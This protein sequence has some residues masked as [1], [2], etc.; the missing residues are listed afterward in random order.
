MKINQIILFLMFFGLLLFYACAPGNQNNQQEKQTQTHESLTSNRIVIFEN[1]Y[2]QAIQVTLNPGEE[3]APHEGKTRLIY[4]LCDYTIDWAGQSAAP[5]LKN[6]KKGDVHVHEP[7]EL[8]LKNSGSTKAEW[9]AFTRKDGA[10]PTADDQSLDNDANGLDGSFAK[11]L[12]DNEQFRITEIKLAAGEAIPLHDGIHRLIYS[13]SDYS[14]RYQSSNEGTS[15]KSFKKGAVHWHEAD[16]HALENI[17]NT[18]AHFL[19]VA[20]KK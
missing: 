19:I 18:E 8:S 3:L 7:G 1:D 9:V 12:F 6:W 20:Y 2:A 5:I 17:G 11:Q 4:S 13:L 16:Q 10:L 14:I 15:E